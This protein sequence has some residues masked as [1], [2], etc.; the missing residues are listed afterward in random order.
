MAW[1]DPKNLGVSVVDSGYRRWLRA[2]GAFPHPNILGGFLVVALVWVIDLLQRA[3]DLWSKT[4]IKQV[5]IFEMTLLFGLII[6]VS[7]IALSFSRAAWLATA[8]LFLVILGQLI[9]KKSFVSWKTYILAL[10]LSLFTGGLWVGIYS[11][12]FITRIQASER[13]E[14]L[15]FTQ[16]I[17]SFADAWQTLL[18]KPILGT[19]VGVYTYSLHQQY[20]ERYVWQLQPPHNTFLLILAEL[21]IFGLSIFLILLGLLFWHS[22]QNPFFM[23]LFIV[24]IFL[25]L[26]DHWW[27]SLNF[28]WYL[29]FALIAIKLIYFEKNE[30][31]I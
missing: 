30:R 27:W 8:V 14:Q 28:G 6:I 15:S 31:N 26:F 4:K 9:F 18:D 21:G 12:P 3:E 2:Y 29:L 19:G 17:D 16:R 25:M 1:Q 24:M 23:L 5:Q 13:L 7:G 20:P 10:V 22:R 11:E